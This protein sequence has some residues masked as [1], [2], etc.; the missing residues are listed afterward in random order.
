MDSNVRAATPASPRPSPPGA[1][2]GQELAAIAH[3]FEQ[4]HYF[5]QKN[6]P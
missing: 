3:T 5:A 4:N 6:T 1:E 2:N